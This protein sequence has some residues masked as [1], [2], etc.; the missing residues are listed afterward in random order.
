VA[1]LYDAAGRLCR[2]VAAAT[3]GALPDLTGLSN[4][5]SGAI[6]AAAIDTR[7]A[8]DAAGNMAS[9]TDAIS[10]QVV[11]A[12]YDGVNRPTAVTNSGG[13]VGTAD[14]GTTYGYS[15]STNVTRTDPS[16]SYVF[17]LDQFGRPIAMSNPLATGG[18]GDAYAW[19]YGPSGALASAT[20]PLG[21]ADT[22]HLVTTNGYDPV[23]VRNP[24]SITQRV[25]SIRGSGRRAGLFGERL[26][27]SQVSSLRLSP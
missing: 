18:T 3:T 4:P 12:T 23:G 20:E 22:T 7:Y 17:T 6:P 8:Y 9:A 1:W 11:S 25:R 15:S 10:G 27:G 24:D 26:E 16:G 13:I 14:P 2:R 5:C 19:T 21:S